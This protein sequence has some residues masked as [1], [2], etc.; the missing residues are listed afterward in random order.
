MVAGHATVVATEA[1]QAGAALHVMCPTGSETKGLGMGHVM[2]MPSAWATW[3]SR[4]VTIMASAGYGRAL[5]SVGGAH[6]DHGPAPLVDPMNMQ[7]LTF[8]AGADLGVG[9]GLRVGG[10]TLGGIPIG[11]GITRVIGA[12]R[13]AWG[14]PRVSTALEVQVGLAGDPFTIRGVVETA[15]RF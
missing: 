12:G 7:E 10:S 9:H 8:R 13:V 1:L 6:H 5:T 14:T 15:L 3:R 4:P 2:A 11:T